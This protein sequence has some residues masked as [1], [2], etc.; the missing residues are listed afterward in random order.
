MKAI[1]KCTVANHLGKTLN[2]R[3]LKG[4]CKGSNRNPRGVL[5]W[6]YGS[7]CSQAMINVLKQG[8][9]VRHAILADAKL[10]ITHMHP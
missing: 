3:H 2:L 6:G 4:S 9:V 7:V 5:R 1:E 8:V 10:K